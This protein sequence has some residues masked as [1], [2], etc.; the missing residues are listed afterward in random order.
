V[1]L[2]L[3]SEG[4]ER[5]TAVAVLLATGRAGPFRCSGAQPGG[6]A[7]GGGGHRIPVTADQRTSVPTNLAVGDVDD[8]IKPHAPLA[9]DEGR[10]FATRFTQQA[11]AS[12]SWTWCL[13]GFSQ[14]TLVVGL[15]EEQAI[16]SAMRRMASSAPGPAFRPDENQALPARGP[17]A[18]SS[19]L[20]QPPQEKGL[21]AHM[22]GETPAII[23]QMTA[24]RHS[25]WAPPSHFDP[26][27]CTPPSPEEFVTM[28]N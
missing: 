5:F 9:V 7:G 19:W 25:A 14:P 16:L 18:C 12:G 17:G 13:G 6:R 23:Y 15:S 1:S 20:W 8:R 26:P 11:S 2:T 27:R 3:T 24:I 28:P 4:G 10:A 22:V 21:G